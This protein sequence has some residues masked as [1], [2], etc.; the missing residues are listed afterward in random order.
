MWNIRRYRAEEKEKW[1]AFVKESRNST[2]L[3]QRGYMDYHSDRFKDFSLMAFKGERLMA[4]L[5]ANFDEDGCLHSH[6]GLTYGGWLLPKAHVDGS[7]LL[8]IFEASLMFMREAG[9][10]ELD[11]KAMPYIYCCRPSEE[12]LYALYR[13]GAK[14]TECNLSAAIDLRQP[15]CFNKLRR[16]LLVKA[17]KERFTITETHDAERFMSLVADC[18]AER[19]DAHPV[20]T[21][22]EI[23]L[24]ACR[25]PENIRM[26]VAEAEGTYHAGV[27]IYDTGIVA[28]ARYIATTA[29]GRERNLLTPLFHWLITEGYST[30]NYFDFGTCNEDHGSYLNACLLRQKCSYG[31]TGLAYRRYTLT[32]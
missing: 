4:L 9:M 26:F 7:D 25:F 8:E 31:A 20:H 3:F 27:M 21:A 15:V 6:Q 22:E 10:R 18:L 1:D 19:H 28:H 32:L 16:R 14:E 5:P 30:R 12:D 29:E 17:E 23:R 13:L 2:F 11:Y 24:L